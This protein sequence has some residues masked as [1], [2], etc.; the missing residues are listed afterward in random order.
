MINHFSCSM[1]ASIPTSDASVIS[2]VGLDDTSG[3]KI[4]RSNMI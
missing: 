3:A 4:S 2:I 1:T